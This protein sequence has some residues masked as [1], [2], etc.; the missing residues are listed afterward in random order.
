MA[1]RLDNPLIRAPR[2]EGVAPI[3]QLNG[4][5]RVPVNTTVAATGTVIT[6]AAPIFPGFT[7]VSGADDAKGV[8]LQVGLIGDV[9]I[10]KVG[11]GADLKVWP[12]SGSVINALNASAAMTVIDD[13]CFMVIKAT[14]TQYYTLPLL[15]S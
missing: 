12:P 4:M 15:P 8:I 1:R 14:A 9:Y 10:I 5:P 3:D 6:D 11:D 7:L 13:V 2:Y